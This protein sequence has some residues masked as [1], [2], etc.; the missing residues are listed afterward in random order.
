MKRKKIIL[1][2]IFAV[3][4]IGLMAVLIDA[5]LEKN[6]EAA[7]LYWVMISIGFV[8]VKLSLDKDEVEKQK[9]RAREEKTALFLTSKKGKIILWSVFVFS[10]ICMG[11]LMIDAIFA[12]NLNAVAISLFF[13]S[14]GFISVKYLQPK[15]EKKVKQEKE[16]SGVVDS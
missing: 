8:F 5:L 7:A 1:W 14:I 2:S 9:N 15:V 13:I 12:K 11:A 4:A 16:L 6:P 3:N 10:T